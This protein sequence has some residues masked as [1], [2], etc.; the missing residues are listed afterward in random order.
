MGGGVSKGT[1]SGHKVWDFSLSQSCETEFRC[2]F[3][4]SSSVF[5]GCGPDKRHQSHSV[6]RWILIKHELHGDEKRNNE[7]ISTTVKSTEDDVCV[8]ERE[9]R[10]VR[11][12]SS[13]FTGKSQWMFF[14]VEEYIAECLALKSYQ[15]RNKRVYLRV[16]DALSACHL[17]YSIAKAFENRIWLQHLSK[18]DNKWEKMDEYNEIKITTAESISN[19]NNNY[20]YLY[21]DECQI[22]RMDTK[23]NHFFQK[24]HFNVCM[25]FTYLI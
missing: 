5:S 24:Q 10:V 7:C 9:R 1:G 4:L 14:G 3:S 11:S 15:K 18:G 13:C 22:K 16:Q 6:E 25:V 17:C 20:N 23:K 12:L 19:I 21:N 2:W 8:R